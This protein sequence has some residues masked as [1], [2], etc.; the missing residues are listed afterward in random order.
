MFVVHYEQNCSFIA[1]KMCMIN[2]VVHIERGM[3]KYLRELSQI[4]QQDLL[5]YRHC[6]VR[7]ESTGM[8]SRKVR[9]T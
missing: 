8:R 3:H 4:D 9:L 2:S 7:C 1:V 5:F 6:R